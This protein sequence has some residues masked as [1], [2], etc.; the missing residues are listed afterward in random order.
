MT[1]SQ[2]DIGRRI[3]AV[4]LIGVG[5]LFLLAQLT[6]FDVFGFIWP[7]FVILPG[8]AFL[9]AALNGDKNAAGLAVPGALVTGTGGI[10]LYQNMTG[11]WESWAY[12]WALYP[13]FLGLALIYVGRR[14]ENEGTSKAGQGFVRWGGV[15]FVVL[16]AIFELAI[17]TEN[18]PF[19]NLLLP[20]VLI[21]A[22]VILLFRGTGHLDK[23]KRDTGTIFTGPRVITVG[24]AKNGYVP[25]ASDK[26]RQEIDAALAEDDDH[27]PTV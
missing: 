2:Q 7:F 21:G 8:A 26:L 23:P 25:S 3:G 15:V 20:L 17:F 22:G 6:D 10:L 4:T 11:H 13:V 18:K 24:K 14:T 19:G 9:L 1:H 16:W 27:P 12:I 5:A